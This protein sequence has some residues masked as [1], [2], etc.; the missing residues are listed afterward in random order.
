MAVNR[1]NAPKP[2]KPLAPEPQPI[3]KGADFQAGD[4]RLAE[5]Q[6]L[7]IGQNLIR[8]GNE[9]YQLDLGRRSRSSLPHPSA[10][11]GTGEWVP[12]VRVDRP[13]TPKEAEKL[14]QFDGAIP[15]SYITRSVQ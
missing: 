11:L 3:H 6:K 12:L 14:I 4:Y 2:I 1:P 7:G 5:P 13:L 15:A 10:Q 9:V 8:I